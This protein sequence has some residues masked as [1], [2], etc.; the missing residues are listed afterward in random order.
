VLCAFLYVIIMSLS[1]GTSDMHVISMG[2]VCCLFGVC[3]VRSATIV[4][5]LCMHEAHDNAS[6]LYVWVVCSSCN[7]T[8]MFALCEPV[9]LN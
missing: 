2:F 7:K 3:S 9:R 4:V 1:K 6:C 5:L 8:C